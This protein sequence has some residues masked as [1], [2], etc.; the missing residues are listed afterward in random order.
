MAR[1][2]R[3]INQDLDPDTIIFLG[4]LFDGGREW[5]TERA[6]LLNNAQ[7]K[8]LQDM[9][10]DV[11]VQ[12]KENPGT[13]N[14]K[15]SIE[16]Y[17]KALAQPHD[18]AVKKK[19]H[20]LNERGED[21]KEFVHGEHGRWSRWGQKQ[22]NA[23]FARFVHIFFDTEQL[24]PGNK[25]EVFPAYEVQSDPI[26]VENGAGNATWKEYATVGGKQRRVIASLP[27]NHDLGFG[28]GVQL[29]VRDRFHLHFGESNRVDVIGNHTFISL[30][31]PSLS[32][33]SQY[34]PEGGETSSDKAEELTHIWQPTMHYMQSLK[35]RSSKLVQKALSGYYSDDS[36]KR[37]YSHSVVDPEAQ[38]SSPNHVQSSTSSNF[39]LPVVLLTHVPLYRDP[40]TDCGRLREGGR[41]IP[42]SAGYQYQNI[43]TQSLTAKIAN[44]VS[45]AGE[46]IHIFSGDDHDYCDVNHRYNIAHGLSGSGRSVLRSVKEITVKSFSWAM[47]VRRPGFLLVSLWNP[48]N[49]QGETIGTPLPTIQTHL[50]LL[51]DQLGVFID[52]ALFLGMTIAMLLIRAVYLG[53]RPPAAGDWEEGEDGDSIKLLPPR[54]RAKLDGRANG[55]STPSRNG[56]EAKGR[57]RAS[58]TSTSAN[59]NRNATLGVQRSYNA[60]TRSVSPA[61]GIQTGT[62]YSLP[63]LQEH[64]GPLIEKAGYYPPVRWSDP[65][66]ESDEEKSVGVPVEQEEDCQGKL[67]K[68]KRTRFTKVRMAINEFLASLVLVGA[69]S[70]LFY[71]W[72]IKNG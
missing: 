38:S 36:P 41:A 14:S 58:S 30:D 24:Y 18:H 4:D 68:R 16:S 5:A 61:K 65:A 26:I 50:C 21:L 34:M 1:N 31:T 59:A 27:G 8:N 22:W 63:N 2:F 11:D 15:R 56:S 6:R 37:G 19:D 25:R 23:E 33:L 28:L 72:L 44:S 42:I 12:A 66:D 32:A 20:F 46:L 45:A 69:P 55:Y 17:N 53:L 48:V 60:R 51:P 70:T 29:A 64:S 54:F 7:K 3:L 43:I 57:Q 62:S 40:E 10:I 67:R 9:R 47:G 52:Y 35:D 49:A 13:E 39:Q 71:C